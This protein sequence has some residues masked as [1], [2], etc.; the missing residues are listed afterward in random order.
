VQAWLRQYGLGLDPHEEPQLAELARTVDRLATARAAL[1]A[2]EPTAPAWPRLAAEERQQR[3]AYGRVVAALGLPTG[4]AVESS[5]KVIGL[6]TASRR[7]LR[8]ARARWGA[9]GGER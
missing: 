7:G 4:L 2:M 1:A 5:G 3:L 8:A 6:S 9:A